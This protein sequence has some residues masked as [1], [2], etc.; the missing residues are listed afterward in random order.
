MTDQANN[1]AARKWVP[2]EQRVEVN[3]DETDPKKAID[4]QRIEA[5]LPPSDSDGDDPEARFLNRSRA[6]KKRIARIQRQFDQRI[7]ERDAEHQREISGL[8]DE[9]NGLKVRKNDAPPVDD[10][11]HERT[12]TLLQ[13]ELAAAHEAGESKKVAELTARI[14]RLEAEFWHKK[15]LA[16]LGQQ[17]EK[18]Q[19]EPSKSQAKR[20]AEQQRDDVPTGPTPTAKRWMRVNDWWDDPDFSSHKAYA[21]DVYR[22]LI[23]EEDM[24]PDDPETFQELGKRLKKTFKDLEVNDPDEQPAAKRRA[25]RKDDDDDD[26]LNNQRAAPVM[27]VDRG[28]SKVRRGRGVT[29]TPE[30]IAQMKKW[31]RD[32]NN[33]REVLAWAAEKQALENT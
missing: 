25:A 29:L 17:Q 30:D 20:Y 12:I 19:Q 23:Q 11:A 31:G 33:D 5:Q 22:V 4:R 18:P 28:N 27:Q 7:A 6:V 24:D 26:E 15:T 1:P 10:A 13:A 14:N 8:R 2:P 21:N 3:L 32:P 9:I 16:T